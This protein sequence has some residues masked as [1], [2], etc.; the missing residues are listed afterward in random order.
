VRFD[1][2]AADRMVRQEDALGRV[3]TI[4]HD[5]F[6][7]RVEEV[8]DAAGLAVA[9]RWQLDPLS[10]PIR[11]TDPTGEISTY[12]YDGVGRMRATATPNG[13]TTTRA[14]GADGRI[15]QE[16]LGSGVAFGYAYDAAGRLAA[17]TN[18]AVPPGVDAIPAHQ[19]HYDGLGRV[20]QADLGAETVKRAYDSRGRLVAET[21][22]G[23]TIQRR[24]DEASGEVLRIWPDG[25]TERHSHDLNGTVT[26]IEQIAAGALGSGVTPLALLKPSGGAH[27]GSADL[28]GSLAIQARYDERKRLVD[29]A[30]T[31]PAGADQR[32]RYR[33][34]R[35]N[36]RRIEALLG[37]TSALS[38]FEFDP[39]YR[40]AIAKKGFALPL[41][42]APL[43]ADQ[44]AAIAAASGAS[45]GAPESEGYSYDR[46]DARLTATHTGEANR[47]YTYL[48]GH[49]ILSD[50]LTAF[51]HSAE[52]VQ[53]GDGTFTYRADALGRITTVKAGASTVL[54]LAYD[55]LGRPAVIGEQ[56]RPARRLHYFGDSADQES[57]AGIAVRQKT[58]HATTGLPLAYHR[59]GATHFTLFDGRHN[60][61]AL[62]D[63]Q[64]SLIETYRYR[65]FGLP[66]IFDPGGAV[67]PVSIFG[68]EP[69]FGGQRHIA[70]T[71]LYLSKRRLMNP[72][73]G[74][75]LSPDPQGYANSSSL[76]V[77]AAQNPIDLID[78]DGDFAFLAVLAVMA[79]GALVAGGIN[80]VRQ[81]I[82]M[83]EDPRKR[84]EGFSWS[85]LGISMGLGAVI[86]PALV[87]APEL[88]IPLAAYGVAGG[89]EQYSEGN[90]ATGTFDIVTSVLPFASKTVRNTSTGRGTYIGQWR[91][92]GPADSFSTRTGRFTVI[93][94][95]LENYW[96]SP[97]GKEIG[98]GFSKS[99]SGPD[100]HVAVIFENEGG[101]FWFGEKNAMHGPRIM[102]PEGPKKTYFANFNQ[103]EG[104]PPIYLDMANRPFEYSTIR[105]PRAS[106][107]QAMSYAKGRIPGTGVEPF[108]FTCANCSHFVGDTLAQGGFKGMGNGK[109]LGL[110]NDFTNFNNSSKMSYAA[111]WFAKPPFWMQTPQPASAGGKK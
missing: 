68:A 60:L 66:T 67:R 65:P 62:A 36:R 29:L 35:A 90:Y 32:I 26:K 39:K 84:A 8:Y 41:A 91:G 20:V 6:G 28:P 27:F 30:A 106:A 43:Q 101:G 98:V 51:T 40:L 34:D 56:G 63:D 99:V 9:H 94:N 88:A 58:I 61:V 100:G 10:R 4:A 38:Y 23:V 70:S 80:A 54:S 69:I 33:Y 96:P 87:F 64:G 82:Q 95:N 89:I 75:F 105:I 5:A 102:T 59:P 50:G 77:Y 19:F 25:R 49:R 71:G 86:A 31:S 45:A 72:V 110:W 42:D 15:A 73:H 79:V 85:E 16:T 92:L 21:S 3:K 81:G 1:Y 47:A 97:T 52:G 104:L 103:Q 55:S 48:P 2:D 44:D 83:S 78:P 13:V 76:Y 22:G 17:I 108:D 111:P 18:A 109:A 12:A 57:E 107:N 74:L 24:F 93:E 14:Y 11:Y 7:Q 46:S 37:Q 53:S